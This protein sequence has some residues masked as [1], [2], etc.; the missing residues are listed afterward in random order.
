MFPSLNRWYILSDVEIGTLPCIC[1]SWMSRHMKIVLRK[2]FL[3]LWFVIGHILMILT[4]IGCGPT[5][6][7]WLLWSSAACSY[8]HL[9]IRQSNTL[10]TTTIMSPLLIQK[11]KVL[12]VLIRTS[13]L[14]LPLLCTQMQLRASINSHKSINKKCLF[15]YYTFNLHKLKNI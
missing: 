2:A 14:C 13:H 9:H 7:L 15:S 12:F 5:W 6:S 3:F 1:C 11:P 8:H 4:I 10:P